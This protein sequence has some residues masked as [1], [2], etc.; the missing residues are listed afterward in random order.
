VGEDVHPLFMGVTKHDLSG[1]DTRAQSNRYTAPRRSSILGAGS[2][3]PFW[4][5][6]FFHLMIFGQV[7]AKIRHGGG[8]S[9][10]E[11]FRPFLEN[12]WSG[13][14][15]GGD[16]RVKSYEI[17][18]SILCARYFSNTFFGETTILSESAVKLL[19]LGLIPPTSVQ[20][21]KSIPSDSI[22]ITPPSSNEVF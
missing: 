6:H 17:N 4:F 21:F 12:V 13:G 7:M 15:F 16:K 8:G 9:C 22:D 1:G 20:S 11:A 2:W 14:M 3:C 10:T 19:K 5:D 18:P